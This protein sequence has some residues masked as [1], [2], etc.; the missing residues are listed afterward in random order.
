MENN[1][2]VSFDVSNSGSVDKFDLKA[3]YI[4][5]R[6]VNNHYNIRKGQNSG[7]LK[8]EII[9]TEKANNNY[10]YDI[11]KDEYVNKNYG[12]MVIG[13]YKNYFREL[14]NKEIELYEKL[15]GIKL[16]NCLITKKKY[17]KIE[18]EEKKKEFKNF[19]NKNY[20]K[21]YNG[22]YYQEK[23]RNK[24][25]MNTLNDKI[26]KILNLHPQALNIMKERINIFEEATKN[27]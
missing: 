12:H 14:D 18:D 10:Y 1:F 4:L 3:K 25:I 19:Y 15:T 20:L 27:I 9:I 16:Y 24:Y 22:K 17:S 8:K 21:N 7:T 11:F 6:I 23:T 2:T 26:D 13:N 5:W